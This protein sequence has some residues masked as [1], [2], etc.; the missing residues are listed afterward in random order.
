MNR[1]LSC[2]T[3]ALH[4]ELVRVK[5]DTVS[6]LRKASA[7]A[8]GTVTAAAVVTMDESAGT[9]TL[10][11]TVSLEIT[12]SSGSPTT[13]RHRYRAV[14]TRAGAGWKVSSLSPVPTGKA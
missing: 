7:T 5:A 9:A 3:G 11:T 12:P 13:E 4:Q 14:L 1:W 2:T 10:L 8:V 6:Q